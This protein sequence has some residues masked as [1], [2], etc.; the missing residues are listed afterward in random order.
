MPCGFLVALWTCGYHTGTCGG[1]IQFYLPW[2]SVEGD[3]LHHGIWCV[4]CVA[5]PCGAGSEEN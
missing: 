3:R 1:G 5:S 2:R 4:G